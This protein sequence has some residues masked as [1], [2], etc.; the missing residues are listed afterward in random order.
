M[1]TSLSVDQR[2]GLGSGHA[3][4]L[5]LIAAA[6]GMPVTRHPP[7][8]PG[9]EVFPHP[10]PRLY[11]L[12][13]KTVPSSLSLV[14]FRLV[15]YS[16]QG[17]WLTFFRSYNVRHKFPLRATYFRQV[18][19]HVVGFPHLRLLCLIRLPFNQGPSTS[20]LVPLPGLATYLGLRIVLYPGFPF[21]P[22]YRHPISVHRSCMSLPS[23][24]VHLF[25]HA[26]A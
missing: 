17:G 3:M 6:V 19:H 16:P 13:R 8:R 4:C 26:T 25:I 11:S 12:P 2:L 22:R 1:R 5:I 15:C 24:C 18:L 14:G 21:V 10:V 9:R 7:H 20:V 23:S